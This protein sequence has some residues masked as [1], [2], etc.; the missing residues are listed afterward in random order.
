MRE[1]VREIERVKGGSKKYVRVWLNVCVYLCVRV[2]AF[3]RER[4]RG[5]GN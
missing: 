4:K 1:R 3:E 2:G 5:R